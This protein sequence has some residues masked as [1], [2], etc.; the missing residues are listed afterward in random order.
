[1][2]KLGH[3]ATLAA[4]AALEKVARLASPLDSRVEITPDGDGFRVRVAFLMSRLSQNE[5]DGVTKRRATSALRAEIQELSARVIRDLYDYC[6]S[7]SII[8]VSVTCNH[9]VRETL[10]PDGA[11]PEERALPWQRAQPVLARLYRGSH[12]QSHARA[13]V[14]W[15]RVPL[16]EVRELSSVEYDGLAQMAITPDRSPLGEEREVPGELQF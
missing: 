16:T 15:R 13:I 8:S 3:D 6:G 4:Q 12:D 14:D 11:T 9:T 5:P 1:M 2:E 10:V 7:R